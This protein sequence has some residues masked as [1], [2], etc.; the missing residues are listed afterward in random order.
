MYFT[1]FAEGVREALRE[2]KFQMARFP[3]SEFLAF[4]Q[5]VQKDFAD[6]RGEFRQFR[7]TFLIRIKTFK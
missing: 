3:L 1:L 6:P 2:S 4:L 7:F 5:V